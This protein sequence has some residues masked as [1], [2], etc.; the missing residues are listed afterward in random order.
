MNWGH[1]EMLALADPEATSFL[2]IRRLAEEGRL[3]DVQALPYG[4]RASEELYDL[5]QDPNELVNL[6][7]DPAFR[8]VLE[9][10]R[11]YLDAWLKDTGDKAQYPRSAAAMEEILDRFPESWLRSPEFSK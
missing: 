7:A 5:D 2:M 9:S 4:P 6:A 3:T 10:K 1:R 8:S 11:A